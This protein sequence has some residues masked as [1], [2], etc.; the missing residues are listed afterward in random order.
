MKRLPVAARHSEAQPKTAL[1]CRLQGARANLKAHR[2]VLQGD[3]LLV[4]VKPPI[5][6][7]ASDG[8]LLAFESPGLC[9]LDRRADRADDSDR[10]PGPPDRDDE[11]HLRAVLAEFADSYKRDR[12]HRSLGL[13][14][15]LPRSVRA[16]GRVL[17]RPE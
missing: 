17:S 11:R 7:R 3:R 5:F 9:Q 6:V 13:Q 15:P 2:T 10:M 1:D 16:H 12:P 14:S 8:D 4:A